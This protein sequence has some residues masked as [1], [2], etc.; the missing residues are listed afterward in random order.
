[1]DRKRKSVFASYTDA[2]IANVR[3]KTHGQDDSLK[4]SCS[5][6][7]SPAEIDVQN[8]IQTLRHIAEKST[9]SSGHCAVK[10]SADIRRAATDL[11]QALQETISCTKPVISPAP[12]P[13]IVTSRAS[14][15]PS[16]SLPPLPPILDSKLERAVLTH[17]G[18]SNDHKATYDR[19]EI[20][21]D[22]YIELIAT[23]LIWNRFREI[24]SG[25]ISQIRELLVKN[26]TLA[27]YT[28]NYGIDSKASVPPDYL[29]H[30][31]RW[32]KTRG[33]IFEAYV[34]AVILSHP[35]GYSVAEQW[36]FQLWSP[37][38]ETV[39][40]FHTSPQ[41]KE[42]LAKKIMGKGV[43]LK[44][45]EEKDPLQ[46]E[47]GTE[48]FFIGVYLTGWGWDNKHLGSGQGLNKTIAGNRAAQQALENEELINAIIT[49]KTTRRTGKP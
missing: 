9:T 5:H 42:T 29:R 3:V 18:V 20:L 31:K 27:E 34:A 19:L 39:K 24:S 47:G 26:E 11:S 1:M 38:L 2:S 12:C 14:R 16:G 15:V 36:L 30:P 23:K 35:D 13:S 21:G 33:D 46:H 44:Y 48:T 43:K 7:L 40:E 4:E 45:I 37:K 25:R 17:P 28:T 8:D 41:A 6:F 10:L 49:S 32:T 22:A